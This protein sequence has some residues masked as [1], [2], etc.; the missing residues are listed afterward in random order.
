MYFRNLLG[1][2]SIGKVENLKIK[3]SGSGRCLLIHTYHFM[4]TKNISPLRLQRIDS[5]QVV[6]PRMIGVYKC[7]TKDKKKKEKKESSMVQSIIKLSVCHLIYTHL[8]NSS[9]HT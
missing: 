6:T 7:W 1:I 4:E 2:I 3:A 8:R 9:N 5:P